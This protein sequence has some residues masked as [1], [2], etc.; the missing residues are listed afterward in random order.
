MET[1]KRG[2]TE[3]K[4]IVTGYINDKRVS[5]LFDKPLEF[6]KVI[7]VVDPIQ[8]LNLNQ[9]FIYEIYFVELPSIYNKPIHLNLNV[10]LYNIFLKLFSQ[11]VVLLNMFGNLKILLIAMY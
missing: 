3:L 9:Q 4:V 6:F 2:K 8:I 1:F 5:N 10:I 7:N 11:L